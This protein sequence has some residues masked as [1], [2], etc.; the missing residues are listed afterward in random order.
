MVVLRPLALVFA[1]V[2][3]PL[4]AQ[5]ADD[6]DYDPRSE[7]RSMVETY[8]VS[9]RTGCSV[10]I[11]ARWN[12]PYWEQQAAMRR[13]EVFEQCLE[14]A[15]AREYDRLERLS[16]RIADLRDDYPELDWSGVDYALDTKWADLDR[17]ESKI[18]IQ[19]QWAETAITILDTF[20]G[21]GAPL[22][23]SPLNPARTPYGGYGGYR[24]DSSVSAP[25][26]P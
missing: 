25:G 22:D 23:S 4:C 5:D 1:L 17:V 9:D 14:R 2:S 7:A 6:A 8:V 12:A 20:T 13:R 3:A 10:P 21:P 19:R 11:P 15:Y 16:Y 26:V 24:T 18:A